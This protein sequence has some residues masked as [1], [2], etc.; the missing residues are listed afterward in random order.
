MWQ[1]ILTF[2]LRQA[3]RFTSLALLLLQYHSGWLSSATAGANYNDD[4]YVTFEKVPDMG[5]TSFTLFSSCGQNGQF[6]PTK[7]MC[8]DYY[9]ALRDADG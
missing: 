8:D 7:A 1:A 3:H 6:G 2:S 4:G 9:T 5:L